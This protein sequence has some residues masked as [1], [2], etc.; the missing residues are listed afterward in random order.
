LKV[1]VT[2]AR[3]MLAR[4]LL[5]ELDSRGHEAVGFDRD[6][7]DVTS[8][9][10]VSTAI[11]GARPDAV[12]QCA[13]YTKVDDAETHEAL[14][15]AVNAEAT[16][17]VARACR[18]V[19][20]RLLYPSTDYVFDGSGV[21]PYPPDA[22]V[23]PINAYGRSKL[24]GEAAARESDDVLIVRTS[25]LYGPGGRNFVDTILARARAG[26]PL[27]VVNDQRGAPTATP[28]LARMMVLLLERNAPA[29]VYHATNAGETTWYGLACAALEVA[30][31]AAQI[32]PCGSGEF[33]TAARRPM[34][35]VLDCSG[36]YEVTGPAPHWR[37]ALEG[38]LIEG[39]TNA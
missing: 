30:G 35:S 11:E 10:A 3:G 25:W 27:R 36:T 19:G 24:A 38:V 2:G 34:Y 13:A 1:L 16:A 8:V 26:A 29:G 39:Q 37:E 21:A 15:V 7:L 22:P 12:V 17:N 28:D 6:A 33:V 9:D 4:A 31:I 18:T 14:A 20:A 32:E 23:A 5:R